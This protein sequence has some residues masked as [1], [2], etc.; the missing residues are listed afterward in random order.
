MVKK[1][2]AA[3]GQTRFADSEAFDAT[4]APVL[5]G[6]P[7]IASWLR[8][9]EDSAMPIYQQLEAQLTQSIEEGLL[10]PGTTLPAERYLAEMLGIS[11]TTVQRCYNTLRER[12]LVQGHGRLGTIVQADSA[13]LS[14][15]MDRLRGFTQEMQELGK[16]PSSRILEHAIVC[17]RLVASVFGLPSTSRFLKLVRIRYGDEIPLS[18]ENAWYSLDVAPFLE[19]ADVAGSIYDQLAQHRLALAFCDQ[20]VEATTPTAFECGIFGFAEPVPCLLIKRRSFIRRDVM[21][22]YVEGLFRGDS[23]TYRIRLEA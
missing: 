3:S 18:Y 15:G 4:P 16:R 9:R 2:A 22:E 21:V 12:R 10:K 17:D 8:L 1:F 6:M 11:R 19:A 5:A 23:Y 13:R 14:P 7:H 20:T